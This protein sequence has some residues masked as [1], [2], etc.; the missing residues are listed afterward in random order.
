MIT[1]GNIYYPCRHCHT[2][3][4]N[5]SHYCDNCKKYASNWNTRTNNKRTLLTSSYKWR[6]L[7]QQ[8]IKRD[9]YLCQECLKAGIFTS[10]AEVDH[11]VPIS[12]GGTD[13]L[14][15]LQLLCKRCHA[16]KTYKE[17]RQ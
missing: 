13:N 15:N 14:D 11:I 3:T 1:K 5:L 12:K 2:P 10:G 7:R 17:S 8:V 6:L 16:Q 9:N 4:Q